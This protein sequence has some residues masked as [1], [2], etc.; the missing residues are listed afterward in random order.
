MI[1]TTGT[2]TSGDEFGQ[3][4]FMQDATA[5][6][7]VY[8]SLLANVIAGDS[9]KV[10]GTL[11]LYRGQLEI[12]PVNSFQ[13]IQ[14]NRP[15]PTPKKI[16]LNSAQNISFESM[17][18]QLDC[19]GIASCEPKFD[20]QGYTLYDSKGNSLKFIT[21]QFGLPIPA[22]P[23]TGIGIWVKVDNEFQFWSQSLSFDITNNCKLIPKGEVSF[24]SLGNPKLTW[25]SNEEDSWVEYGID[26]FDKLQVPF[27]MSGLTFTTFVNLIQGQLYSARLVEVSS[28]FDTIYSLPIYFSA[29]STP[30]S[31]IAIF[32][33][34]PV[35]ASY[36]D[37]SHPSAT[38]SSVIE[39]DVIARIDQVT[40][41]MDIAMYNDTRTTIVN[42]IKRAVQRGV[43]VRYV[44]EG[45]NSNSALDGTINFPVLYREGSGIMHNK[46]IVADADI[47]DKAWL[48]TG[49]TNFSSAQLT[50]DPN[51][52]YVINDQALALNYRREFD[53]LWGA[54]PDHTGAKEGEQKSDNT[55]HLFNIGGAH[56]ESYFSPSDE[57]NCHILDALKS[58][59]HQ[60]LIG[61]LLLTK[62]DL[63]DEIIALHQ[64][65]IDLRVII[66]DA[67]TSSLAISR[68]TQAG[69]SLAIHDLSGLFHHKYAIIDE[70]YAD[71]DPTVISGSHNWTQSADNINDE[72]TLI[73]H[74][75]SIA[76]IF[77]QEYEA[78]WAEL[79]T[80]GII[81][82]TDNAS[83][84][85]HPNPASDQIEM[86]NPLADKC[87]I[88]LIDVNGNIIGRQNLDP[89]QTVHFTIDSSIPDGI[90]LVHWSWQKDHAVSKLII[91]R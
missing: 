8:S 55:G 23:L 76:N 28:T 24:D 42:A 52:A 81:Q 74:D 21:S 1:T 46:F 7:S 65:D 47:S 17:R 13:I 25:K 79:N 11:T 71:S 64:Q 68:L 48:W 41:T 19:F 56:I 60:V 75:Q 54:S 78:R 29:A 37:G 82:L 40:S 73:F 18:V 85:L 80:T 27:K 45:S 70:G 36:S 59:D 89:S 12:T 50:T 66:E 6:I 77:R 26:A 9:I 2:I 5:G 84:I 58:A 35:D 63:V 30:S 90:Y 62:D 22:S 38:G 51:H 10:T 43:F 88:T 87:I 67:G 53:E 83:L 20:S 34:K 57:T 49:S 69:V 14:H 3:I 31:P 72:N 15:L 91:Q 16:S 44:A 39:N 86:I 4:R 32:F 61:L 33:D